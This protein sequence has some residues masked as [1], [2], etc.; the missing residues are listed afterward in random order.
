MSK[1][2]YETAVSKL[3]NNG[4]QVVET[5]T[6]DGLVKDRTIIRKKCGIKLLGTVDY[7]VK[8]FRFRVG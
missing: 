3:R 2:N 1:Y 4:V 8:N 6:A 5:F 7:L